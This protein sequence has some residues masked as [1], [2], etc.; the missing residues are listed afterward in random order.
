M[1]IAER[2]RISRSLQAL[3]SVL[4]L[5]L[6]LTAVAAQPTQAQTFTVL[7]SFTGRADGGG[8]QAG[9][10]M[11]TAGNFYGTAA[12]GGSHESGTVFKLK[13]S[14]SGWVFTPLYA[15]Q[16]IPDGDE[17]GAV[18]VGP[19]GSLYGTTV[20]GGNSGCR[21]IGCGTVFNL[22]PP[23]HPSPSVLASWT[24]SVLYRFTG[25]TDAA[26]P[27]PDKLAVDQAGNL[28][29]TTHAYGTYGRGSVFKLTL[30]SGMWTE[31]L[32][33]SFT[34]GSDGAGPVAG[35]IFDRA[36]NLYGTTVEGGTY[37]YGTVYELMSSGSGW[38]EHVLY[39]FQGGS[40]GEYPQGGLLFDTF[41]KIYGTTEGT[42]Q[43][44][45]TAFMLTPSDYGWI[46]TVLHGFTGGDGANPGDALIMGANAD[47]YGTTTQGGSIGVGVVFELAASGGGWTYTV[48]H[49]FSG[50]GDGGF[51]YGDLVVD[52]NG[53]LYGTTSE[54]GTH[55]QGVVFEI[56]P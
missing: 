42:Y 10:A 17:P 36:G 33:Y 18:I 19:D 13:Q 24:E 49:D 41:G 9:L 4:A 55:G 6:A 25:G 30:A 56:T 53:V 12:F 3:T 39:S 45:G 26:N 47:L 1:A 44:P 37:G 35:V 5:G 40:D 31:S 14:G 29:G 21:F 22:K 7:H 32:L 50:N 48:L 11:D 54:G 34:G 52:A 27:N 23:V 28:Y 8:P 51:P 15:F 43:Y 2:Y 16:G 38:A 20:G 46:Q